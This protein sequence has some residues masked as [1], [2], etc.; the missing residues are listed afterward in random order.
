MRLVFDDYAFDDLTWWLE[1]NPKTAKRIIALIQ[2]LK[3]DPFRGRGKPEPLKYELT[4][5]W[6]R[7]IDKVNRLV[8]EVRENEIRILSCRYHYDR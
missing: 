2:E 5:C 8:Y 4:G 6:S 1:K 7:R 3:R